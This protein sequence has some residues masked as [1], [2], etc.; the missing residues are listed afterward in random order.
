M[1]RPH[2]STP[3]APT[4][5]ILKSTM[6]AASHGMAPSA[7][8]IC[9]SRRVGLPEVWRNGPTSA[10]WQDRLNRAAVTL[11]LSTRMFTIA[12]AGG[13]ISRNTKQ[14]SSASREGII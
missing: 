7:P 2:V 3:H 13:E 6:P 8:S 11:R 10:I 14:R 12:R 5:H 4:P 1:P 9:P